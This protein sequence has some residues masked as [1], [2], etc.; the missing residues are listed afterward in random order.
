M[1]AAGARAA[2]NY[3]LAPTMGAEAWRT[4]VLELHFVD[5]PPPGM[6]LNRLAVSFLRFVRPE[7]KFASVGDLR[8]QI[9]A[10]VEDVRRV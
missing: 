8:R 7:S 3:G 5:A 2:A 4:P 9:A 6:Q 1:E 10:D